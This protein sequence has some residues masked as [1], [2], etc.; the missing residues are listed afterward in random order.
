MGKRACVR[1]LAGGDG[2]QVGDRVAGWRWG[3]TGLEVGYEAVT[4]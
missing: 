2:S 3:N 4:G 1:L